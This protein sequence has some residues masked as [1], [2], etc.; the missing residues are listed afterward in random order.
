ML[1]FYN[2][3]GI[4]Q[5]FPIGKYSSADDREEDCQGR[6]LL[7]TSTIPIEAEE[8]LPLLV[9]TLTISLVQALEGGHSLLS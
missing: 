5:K 9:L 3:F 6:E 2:K 1:L 4:S 8:A 7:L